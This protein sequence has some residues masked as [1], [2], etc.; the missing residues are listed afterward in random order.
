VKVLGG[1]TT[2]GYDAL[3]WRWELNAA[4]GIVAEYYA[5]TDRPH[6]RRGG[7]QYYYVQD[8]QGN[9]IGLLNASGAVVE[10]Y[11]YTPQG[12]LVGGGG[13]GVTNPYRFKGREWDAEAGLYYMRARYYDPVTSRFVSEDPIGLAGGLNPYVFVGADPVN[14]ADPTGLDWVW[15]CHAWGLQL[16]E[17]EPGHWIGRP[18]CTS[19]GVIWQLPPVYADHGS[20]ANPSGCGLCGA[21]G[22][23]VFRRLGTG[24]DAMATLIV[25]PVAASAAIAAGVAAVPAAAGTLPQ[26]S[27]RIGGSRV[28]LG[29]TPEFLNVARATGMRALNV[30]NWDW[31]FNVRWLRAHA[32]TR[33]TFY[34]ASSIVGQTG[35]IYRD[36]LLLLMSWGYRLSS[37]GLR[38]LPPVLR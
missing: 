28:V 13:S 22:E 10:T 7:V 25:A 3:R 38:L 23:E 8:A 4:G 26:T 5:G 12:E 20:R 17:V 27:L 31:G 15:V 24:G 9:V 1:A 14:H 34:L 16:Q 18:I 36:E 35:T 11:T 37:D 29:R 2:Y 33:A 32:A 19:G 21:G 6:M 30:K